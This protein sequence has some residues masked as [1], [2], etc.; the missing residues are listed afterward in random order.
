MDA[1]NNTN[2]E[3]K[4]YNFTVILRNASITYKNNHTLFMMLGDDFAFIKSDDTY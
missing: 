3:E 4:A 2:L 1:I